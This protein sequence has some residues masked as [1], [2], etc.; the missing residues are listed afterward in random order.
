MAMQPDMILQFAHFL[1]EHYQ[2]EG[3]PSPEVRAEVYVT[4]NGRPSQLLLDPT[5]NLARIS[6]SW[7]H[8]KWLMPAPTP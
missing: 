3:M 2:K 5:I 1:A 8:K 7:Q 4:F 6:D